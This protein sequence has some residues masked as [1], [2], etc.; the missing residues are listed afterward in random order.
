MD[1]HWG[2]LQPP[3][4]AGNT[5]TLTHSVSTA[6][7]AGVQ[8]FCYQVVPEALQQG[9]CVRG[10]HDNNIKQQQKWKLPATVCSCQHECSSLAAAG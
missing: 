9:L 1:A 7:G 4:V 10:A 3:A 2:L 5:W 6:A 8:D